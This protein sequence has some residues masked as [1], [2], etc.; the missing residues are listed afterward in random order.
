M[1]PKG[2]EWLQ[3]LGVKSVRYVVVTPEGKDPSV[4][5]TIPYSLIAE[6]DSIITDVWQLRASLKDLIARDS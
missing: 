6:T 5:L 3:R 4:D 2:L 1:N